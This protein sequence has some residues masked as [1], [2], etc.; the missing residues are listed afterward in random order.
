MLAPVLF[1]A[2]YTAIQATTATT[3]LARCKLKHTWQKNHGM[4]CQIRAADLATL[5]QQNSIRHR[6]LSR[7][8][9]EG[10]A[11]SHD[12]SGDVDGDD[13]EDW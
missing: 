4:L 5:P 2:S 7:R 1:L 8:Y 13:D 12:D 3:S 11:G 10:D 6:Q 9:D